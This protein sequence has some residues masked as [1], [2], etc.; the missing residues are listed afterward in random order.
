MSAAETP[1]RVL[2]HADLDADDDLFASLD[3]AA[4]ELRTL[5]P[6]LPRRIDANPEEVER[7]LAKLVLTVIEL[8]RRLLEKQAIRRIDSG[9]LTDEEIER[10]GVTF[11]RLNQRMKELQGAFG[12]QDEDLNLNLGPL[13][14]LM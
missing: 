8:L 11:L 3:R 4:E 7:G 14:D 6:A 12:L 10:L 5:E 1:S 2:T 9:N 13:G